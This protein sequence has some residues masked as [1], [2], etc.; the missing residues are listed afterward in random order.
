MVRLFRFH[1]LS[2]LNRKETFAAE[3]EH[4]AYRPVETVTFAQ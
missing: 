2:R 3:G 4:R 1:G